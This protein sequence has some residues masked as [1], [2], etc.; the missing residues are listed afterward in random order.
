MS[1]SRVAEVKS[2]LG[3]KVLLVAMRGHEELGRP[4]R[5]ELDL[6]ST[7]PDVDFSSVLGQTMTVELELHDGSL[8]EFTGH[9]T[10]FSLAGGSGRS[11]LYRAV[12]RPWLMLL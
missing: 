9:V 7:D 11:V 1:L 3:D 6:K 8:R 2:P 5:Y 12:L 4:F 10:E